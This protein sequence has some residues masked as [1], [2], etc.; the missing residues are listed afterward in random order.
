MRGS[1]FSSVKLFKSKQKEE[2]FLP[3]QN[4]E[5]QNEHNSNHWIERNDPR[6]ETDVPVGA[7]AIPGSRMNDVK[8]KS[9]SILQSTK[10]FTLLY[11]E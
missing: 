5:N 11:V 10:D 3:N 8:Q 4:Q 9:L 2:N 7:F 1:K 6:L